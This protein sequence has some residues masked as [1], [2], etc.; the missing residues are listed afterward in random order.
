LINDPKWMQFAA[1]QGADVPGYWLLKFL[2]AERPRHVESGSSPVSGQIGGNA[3]LS[4]R[5]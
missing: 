2:P 5:L 4:A 3:A 1:P